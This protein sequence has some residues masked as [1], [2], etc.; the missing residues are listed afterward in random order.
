VYAAVLR[1]WL[2]VPTEAPL[3]GHF[4]PLPLFRA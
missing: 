2:E 4:E 1:D 3:G